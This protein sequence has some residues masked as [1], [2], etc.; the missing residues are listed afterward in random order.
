MELVF[1]NEHTYMV[2]KL[3]HRYTG[4]QTHNFTPALPY[5]TLSLPLFQPLT[6]GNYQIQVPVCKISYRDRVVSRRNHIW[7]MFSTQCTPVCGF[8]FRYE[9]LRDD[10]TKST[11]CQKLRELKQRASSDLFCN[12]DDYLNLYSTKTSNATWQDDS[13]HVE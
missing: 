8:Q 4:T 6:R 3:S 10:R 12:H 9:V 13:Q 5:L 1:I 7:F 11:E 2:Q